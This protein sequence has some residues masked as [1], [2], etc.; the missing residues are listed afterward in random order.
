MEW[1]NPGRTG[2][3]IY[4]L[5]AFVVGGAATAVTRL[6]V[7]RRRGLRRVAAD[8]PDGGVIIIANHTSY[9]DGVILA[10]ACRRLG[11]S[12]RLLATAGV[13]RAPVIGALASRLGFIRVERGSSSAADALDAAEAALR[14]GEAVALFP[15]GRTTRDPEFWPERSKTGAV[16]L[17]LR[18]TAPI[19]PVAMVGAHR[20]VGRRR[21]VRSLLTSL[22]LRPEVSIAVGE[23]IDVL[24][25]AEQTTP[26]SDDVRRLADEVMGRLIDLVAELRGEPAPHPTGVESVDDGT[27]R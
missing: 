23:P 11:R 8:L 2:S 17:A 20:I 21:P 14:A 1:R 19:V 27:D 6:R 22:L 16:R 4:L 13:F 5:L 25:L 9:A 3:L 26:E 24:S 7:A 12:V 10:L 18:S 15:E